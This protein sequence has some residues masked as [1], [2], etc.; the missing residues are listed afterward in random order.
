MMY[1]KTSDLITN[2]AEKPG[3][4]TCLVRRPGFSIF[5]GIRPL[6]KL[7]AWKVQAQGL[8]DD[9]LGFKDGVFP[10][11]LLLSRRR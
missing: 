8:P 9:L 4:R 6:Y 5:S 1:M 11:V 2:N 3:R 10:G 7:R